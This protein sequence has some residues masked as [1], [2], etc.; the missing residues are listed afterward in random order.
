MR[1]S[2]NK[3]VSKRIETADFDNWPTR[4]FFSL[5]LPACVLRMKVANRRGLCTFVDECLATNAAWGA[6]E[7]NAW[8][9]LCA[10]VKPDMGMNC[11]LGNFYYL[12]WRQLNPLRE[13][14]GPM[15]TK[16]HFDEMKNEI[17][18]GF[19]T[20]CKYIYVFICYSMICYS[21]ICIYMQMLIS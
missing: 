3:Q 5:H 19:F 6:S 17:F 9:Q 4:L 14:Y 11:Q 21:I 1:K 12:N 20:Q 16:F 13:S 15:I 18:F 2:N 7:M 10:Y 8:D